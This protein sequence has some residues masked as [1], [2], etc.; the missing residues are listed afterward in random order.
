MTRPVDLAIGLSLNQLPIM[1]LFNGN[2]IKDLIA[3]D[4]DL[5]NRIAK[6]GEEAES[7]VK[8][9]LGRDP[10]DWTVFLYDTI[11]ADTTGDA[12]GRKARIKYAEASYCVA[13]ALPT[14]G[15]RPTDDGGIVKSIGI[16]G[17]RR[18]LASPRE[19][20]E[21]ADSLMTVAGRD[22][23]ILRDTY[24]QDVELVNPEIVWAI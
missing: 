10:D 12:A 13:I 6:R 22:L 11:I 4:T 16:E 20:R 15:I 24:L 17:G 8:E 3:G 2:D 18:E 5:I 14:L 21:H 7:R 23:E 9:I 1:P 19:V